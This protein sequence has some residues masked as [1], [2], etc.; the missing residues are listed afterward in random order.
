MAV[1]CNSDQIKPHLQRCWMRNCVVFTPT[2]QPCLSHWA[3]IWKIR[4]NCYFT[5]CVCVQNTCAREW[6]KQ[7]VEC[8]VPFPGP[9]SSPGREIKKQPLPKR[10]WKQWPG[11]GLTVAAV[12]L[13]V[14]AWSLIFLCVFNH[15]IEE[16]KKLLSSFLFIY[17]SLI[18]G[19]LVRHRNRW[20]FT[21]RVV[22]LSC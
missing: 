18:R 17:S 15:L 14:R 13:C 22:M 1:D 5:M 3:F 12:C 10:R 4:A 8:M 2:I 20:N 16:Q 11:Q 21:C 6:G 7:E 9:N 19:F